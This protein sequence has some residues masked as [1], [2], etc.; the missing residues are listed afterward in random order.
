VPLPELRDDNELVIRFHSLDRL[1]KAKRPRPRWKA[2]M[3]ENQQLRWFRTT[4]LGRTPGWSPPAAAVGPWRDVW[5]ERRRHFEIS[6]L[7]IRPSV[8][9]ERAW[10]FTATLPSW[11]QLLGARLVVERG[12]Q[13]TSAELS[14]ERARTAP[15]PPAHRVRRPLVA[16]YAW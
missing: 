6:D 16:T 11:R 2:P 4:L 15:A 10:W 7:R 13:R 3:I 1:V 5:L 9:A 8:E 14:L 12:G